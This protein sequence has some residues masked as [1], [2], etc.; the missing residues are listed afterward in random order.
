MKRK[1]SIWNESRECKDYF[2]WAQEFK[3]LF[4]SWDCKNVGIEKSQEYDRNACVK[5]R[6]EKHRISVDRIGKHVFEQTEE[7]QRKRKK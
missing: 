1:M 5:Q 3:G 2:G 6:I 7:K 4:R